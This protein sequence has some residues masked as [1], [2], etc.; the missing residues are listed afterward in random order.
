[1]RAPSWIP[2]FEDPEIQTYIFDIGGEEA[3]DLF[4][5]IHAN[6]PVSGEDIM[7]HY[8]DVKPSSV[9]KLL[10]AM[11]QEHALEYHKDTD[12]KGWET[13]TW[14][15]DLPEIRLIHMRKWQAEATDL[16]KQLKF[17]KDHEFYACADLHDRVIFEDAMDVE[18]LCPSCEQAM[19]PVDNSKE[20][21]E[22]RSRLDDL[23]VALTN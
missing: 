14:A 7:A 12:A 17:E 1:M 4:S 18:F 2:T 5:F 3:L 11:M 9:R 21:A 16:G 20:I 13:F 23:Q 15:T 10:Y 19:S 22:I 6:E 8:E